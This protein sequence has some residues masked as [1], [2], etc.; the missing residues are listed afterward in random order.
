MNGLGNSA[1]LN[2]V[3][4]AYVV[5]RCGGLVGFLCC[6]NVEDCLCL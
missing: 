1:G 3:E 2:E 4:G 6:C 5:Q